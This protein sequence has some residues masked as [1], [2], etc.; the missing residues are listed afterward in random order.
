MRRQERRDREQRER[1]DEFVLRFNV[2]TGEV[3]KKSAQNKM[4][5]AVKMCVNGSETSLFP[6]MSR[7]E[8]EWIK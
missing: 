7:A 4:I 2:K 8:S 3:K 6:L 1:G 5:Q